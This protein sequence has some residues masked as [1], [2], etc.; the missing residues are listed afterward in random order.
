MYMYIY[1]YIYM[2]MKRYTNSHM[3]IFVWA[4]VSWSRAGAA[5]ALV[6]RAST[7]RRVTAP[8]RHGF[9]QGA[10]RNRRCLT[11]KKA[12]RHLVSA[13]AEPGR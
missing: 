2:Y 8:H 4:M 7:S 5:P 10:A 9:V 11:I 3:F 13:D 6:G 12:T 1:I